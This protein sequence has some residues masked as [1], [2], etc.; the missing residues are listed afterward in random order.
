MFIGLNLYAVSHVD[1]VFR[2]RRFVMC[3]IFLTF[4]ILINGLYRNISIMSY[5]VGLCRLQ[6]V[7]SYHS[8]CRALCLCPWFYIDKAPER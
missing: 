2:R 6:T 1:R 3:A 4:L 7:V 5:A 8:V